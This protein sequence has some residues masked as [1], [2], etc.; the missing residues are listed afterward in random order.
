ME[1]TNLKDL[2]E[3]D[4]QP[5]LP[6]N[7]VLVE[8]QIEMGELFRDMARMYSMEAERVMRFTSNNHF[9]ISEDEF[10]Q[11]FTTLLYCRVMRVNGIQNEITKKYRNDMRSYLIPA[12]ASTLINSIG[13]ATD[14][15]YGFTFIPKM[16]VSV[17]E[18]LTA[19][20][21]R[22][23]TE[24]LR[25]LN[26]EGLTCI[27]TGIAMQPEGDLECMATLNLESDIRSYKKNHPIFGFYASFFKHTI[28]TD[29]L[30]PK[31][32]RIKYG[33]ESDYRMYI[34]YIVKKS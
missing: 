8:V 15:D 28:L 30:D 26:I 27:E 3:K 9:Q 33:A 18:L 10:L 2:F 13:R 6:V 1:I 24:K 21:M 14:S 20:E 16:N 31:S 32:L 12:F 23:I 11:Y 5:A 7:T 17:E 25:T 22:V 34:N 19:E 29:V 4:F